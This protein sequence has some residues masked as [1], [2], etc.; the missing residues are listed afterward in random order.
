MPARIRRVL[1]VES[2][3]ND[4]IATPFVGIF[5]GRCRRRSPMHGANGVASPPPWTCSGGAGMGIAIGVGGALLLRTA[6]HSRASAHRRSSH[7]RR[8]H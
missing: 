8:W 7:W 1:N 2:G 4:G 5:L 3:L 6:G